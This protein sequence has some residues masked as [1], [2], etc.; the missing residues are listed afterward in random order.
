[1]ISIIIP[2][3]NEENTVEATLRNIKK[4][5]DTTKKKYEIIAINDGSTDNSL[6]TLKKLHFIKLINNPYNIGYGAS[7]KTGI[8]ASKYNWILIIDADGTYPVHEIPKLLHYTQNYDMVVG[9]R[10][11]KPY[12]PL[13]RRPA[14]KFLTL[15]A[16][17][18]SGKRIPDLNSGFRVFKKTIAME[19]FHLFPSGFSFT[20]TI[21]LACLTNDYT[22]KFIPIEYYKRKGKSS[23]KP[24]KDFKNFVF[25]IIRLIT[26]FKPMKMFSL[27][28]IILFI[29]AIFIFLYSFLIL[30]KLM[31][32]SVI[33]LFVASLQI[34]LFGALAE[35]SLKKK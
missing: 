4:V 6:L 34:F 2:I 12:I 8:K 35:L 18:L 22:V 25:L 13:M 17:Y 27:I 28:S 32:I 15:L 24:F 1:M 9:A 19:F 10:T 14:K 16:N 31:D 5:M 7:I 30:H 26:Y 20:T 11:K 23:I 33:V 3:Y 21:T 29:A